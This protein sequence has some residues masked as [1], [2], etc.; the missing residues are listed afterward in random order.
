MSSMSAPGM[1]IT[2]TNGVPVET[3]VYPVSDKAD[4][5]DLGMYLRAVATY[6][7]GRLTNNT[8]EFV[9][10][11]PVRPPKVRQNSLPEFAPTE[12]VRRVQE[13]PTGMVVGAPVTATDADGDV[14]NYTLVTGGDATSFA[15]DQATGQITTN[16]A[17]DYEMATDAD[18]NNTYV[19]TVKATDSAGG[20]TGGADNADATV[21]I[22]L[23]DVNEAPDFVVAEG[24]VGDIPQNTEGMA[25]DRPEEGV[26]AENMWTAPY[27][28]STYTVSDPEGVVI[29]DGKWSLAGD[30]AARFQLT[31]ATENVR[32]LEFREKADFEMPMDADKDNIYE[33]TVVA[34]DGVKMAERAVTVKITDS[35]EAGMITLSSENPVTGTPITAELEDSDGDVIKVAWTWYPLESN[36]PRW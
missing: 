33:V 18:T 25:A 5:E 13:G 9:S 26:G 36:T 1:V 31:G 2:D 30:D 17:L 32:T 29:N 7:D 6:I 35:D 3:A 10:V 23:L 27:T 16:G 14:R 21:T 4:S 34:S 22:T 20:E 11:Y 15:I 12:H 28:V 24:D 8:A 19:V